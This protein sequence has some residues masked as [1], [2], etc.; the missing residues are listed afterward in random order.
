MAY[1]FGRQFRRIAAQAITA[2]R[3]EMD[4]L[5]ARILPP[6]EDGGARV[7]HLT[8]ESDCERAPAAIVAAFFADAITGDAAAALLR[9]T[10]DPAFRKVA[11]ARP[12][13]DYALWGPVSLTPG[14]RPPT[15]RTR[16]E[17]GPTT[18][19]SHCDAANG[20]GELVNNNENTSAACCDAEDAPEE[21]YVWRPI[22][23]NQPRLNH[24]DAPA[25]VRCRVDTG[26]PA[27]RDAADRIPEHPP[28]W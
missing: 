23:P 13:Y 27:D 14:W 5:I 18:G 9:Q 22:D 8:I 21:A 28:P 3:A 25:L 24:W 11:V 1:S 2:D 10:E 20:T 26:T 12:R 15:D 6:R 4:A 17:A 19:T 7:L 16:S